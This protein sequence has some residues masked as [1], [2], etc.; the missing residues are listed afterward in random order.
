MANFATIDWPEVNLTGPLPKCTAGYVPD[1]IS[2]LG[3]E[4]FGIPDEKRIT[5]SC[6]TVGYGIIG[7]N[8]DMYAPEYDK[9]H[10]IMKIF[11]D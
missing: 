4:L 10:D 6:V 1:A 8:N 9:I 2:L 11:S 7:Q 3:E 5:A